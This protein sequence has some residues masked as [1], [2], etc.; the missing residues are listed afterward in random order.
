MK[1][2]DY[3]HRLPEDKDAEYIEKTIRRLNLFSDP[4]LQQTMYPVDKNVRLQIYDGISRYGGGRK[5]YLTVRIDTRY[6]CSKSPNSLNR[7]KYTDK[8]H[9]PIFLQKASITDYSILADI[10]IVAWFHS[11]VA[12]VTIL[13]YHC[14]TV[15][16]RASVSVVHMT[17]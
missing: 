7:S 8:C 14:S 15:C 4:T 5:K 1:P 2:A 10:V 3:R 11:T 6:N 16:F 9:F 12:S 13:F 17:F